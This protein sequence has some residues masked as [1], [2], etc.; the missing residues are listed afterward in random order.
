VPRDPPRV[1]APREGTHR[2]TTKARLDHEFFTTQLP[3][4]SCAPDPNGQHRPLPRAGVVPRPPNK[5]GGVH[6]GESRAALPRR[7]GFVRH[8][9]RCARRR[10]AARPPPPCLLPYYLLLA[11][12]LLPLLYKHLRIPCPR[13]RRCL[14][15]PPASS[16]T[17]SIDASMAEGLPRAIAGRDRGPRRPGE[18]ECAA[19]RRLSVAPRVGAAAGAGHQEHKGLRGGAAARDRIPGLRSGRASP[20]PFPLDQGRDAPRQH[21]LSTGG[22]AKRGSSRSR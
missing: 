5:R 14:W 18:Q 3:E 12:L 22:Q 16:G 21:R 20:A 17:S 4:S 19:A 13:R 1:T 2:P 7:P 9:T 8:G 11:F 10:R 15:R 6:R